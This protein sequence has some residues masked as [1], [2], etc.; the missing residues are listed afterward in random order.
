[1]GKRSQYEYDS[2]GNVT[3]MVES[4]WDTT[5]TQWHDYRLTIVA[6]AINTSGVYLVGLPAVQN[7]Y[8]CRYNGTYLSNGECSTNYPSW[9]EQ[10]WLTSSAWSLYDNTCGTILPQPGVLTGQRTF[11]RYL[12]PAPRT[13]STPT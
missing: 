13:R 4:D 10:P 9:P 11:I 6:Y 7:Q 1:V 12:S 5:L 3:R 8:N 2:Y